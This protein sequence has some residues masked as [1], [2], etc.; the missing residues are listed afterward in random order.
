MA[1]AIVRS[2]S[3]SASGSR[4]ITINHGATP[5]SGNLLILAISY[6]TGVDPISTPAGWTLI[7][8]LNDPSDAGLALFRKTA[9]GSEPSSYT[10]TNIL[11]GADDI[12]GVI[13]E[14]SGHNTTTPINQRVNTNQASAGSITAGPATPNVSGCLALAFAS[15]DAAAAAGAQ[16]VTVSSGWTKDRAPWPDYHGLIAAHR[17]SLTSDTTTAINNTFGAFSATDGPKVADILLIAP[18][19]SGGGATPSNLFFF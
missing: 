19:G 10:F 14:I 18:A 4:S 7:S 13:Y 6:Y 2:S 9:G 3:G 11:A 1:V 8:P 12:G 5:A 16:A 15:P 17:N